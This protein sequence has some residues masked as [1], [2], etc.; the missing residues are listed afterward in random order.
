[1]AVAARVSELPIPFPVAM[2]AMRTLDASP[3][4]GPIADTELNPNIDS[5]ATNNGM[6]ATEMTLN[7]WNT[8]SPNAAAATR[9]TKVVAMMEAI[10]R[11]DRTA[12]QSIRIIAQLARPAING[13]RS[14]KVANSSSCNGTLP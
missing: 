4:F 9:P 8:A 10:S 14:A 6:K 13:A 12:I 2:S 11:A 1:M 5:Q 3:P 7:R